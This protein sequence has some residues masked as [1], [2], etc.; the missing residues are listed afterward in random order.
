MMF[1]DNRVNKKKSANIKMGHRGTYVPGHMSRT[2]ITPAPTSGVYKNVACFRGRRE[3][4]NRGT[5]R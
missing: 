2:T 5:S 4:R 1:D 3:E